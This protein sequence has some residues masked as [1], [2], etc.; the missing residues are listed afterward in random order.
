[1]GAGDCALYNS[2]TDTYVYLKADGTVKIKSATSITL[3][4]PAVTITG[5][6]T[7]DGEILDNATGAHINTNNV[8]AMRT[9]FNAHIHPTPAGNSSAPTT[10]M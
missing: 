3:D 10:N 6:L 2:V 7:V 5:N 8:R 4:A 1:M 9:V